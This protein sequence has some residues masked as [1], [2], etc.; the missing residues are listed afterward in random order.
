MIQLVTKQTFVR[1]KVSLFNNIILMS[2]F[3]IESNKTKN[4]K[5]RKCSKNK[6][7]IRKNRQ[8]FSLRNKPCTN[9]R[10]NSSIKFPNEKKCNRVIRQKVLMTSLSAPTLTKVEVVVLF[11]PQSQLEFGENA[12]R[13]RSIVV[14]F[15][16]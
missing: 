3:P 12:E 6:T 15:P 8:R 13:D 7:D 11:N 16:V 9:R 10:D 1:N 5:V 2:L 14:I 4:H